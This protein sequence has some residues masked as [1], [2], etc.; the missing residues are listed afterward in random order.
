MITAI[1]IITILAI[2]S[3]YYKFINNMRWHCWKKQYTDF[4]SHS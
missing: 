1:S 4:H 3:I 2:I